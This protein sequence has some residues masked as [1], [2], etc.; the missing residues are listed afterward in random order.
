MDQLET[1]FL[2]LRQT[3]YFCNTTNPLLLLDCQTW[4]LS[5]DYGKQH[6]FFLRY[7]W[8]KVKKEIRGHIGVSSALWMY[9]KKGEK[10]R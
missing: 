5:N 9:E 1:S 2:K 4:F 3:L 8:K 6:V 10:G 7:N